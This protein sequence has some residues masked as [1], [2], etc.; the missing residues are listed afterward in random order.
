MPSHLKQG[1][2][3][4]IEN[5]AK[6][7]SCE[8]EVWLD[9]AW[10][11]NP[12]TTIRPF[13]SGICVFGRWPSGSSVCHR[14]KNQF[15]IP[16]SVEHFGSSSGPWWLWGKTGTLTVQVC[17][18]QMLYVGTITIY[19]QNFSK[20]CFTYHSWSVMSF[21]YSSIEDWKGYKKIRGRIFWYTTKRAEYGHVQKCRRAKKT[22]LLI[23]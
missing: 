18:K 21:Y 14:R 9:S 23:I 6:L 5:Q 10:P 12:T 8:K 11:F 7:V 20:L 15:R 17:Y 19:S 3:G 16:D 4:K 2:V 13:H 1:I 22:Y